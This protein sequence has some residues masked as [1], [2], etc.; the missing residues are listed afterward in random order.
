MTIDEYAKAVAEA[1]RDAA[2]GAAQ[3]RT[4][5]GAIRRIERIDLDAIIASVPRPTAQG[6]KTCLW[7]LFGECVDREPDTT[8]PA[9]HGQTIRPRR[10]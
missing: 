6:V 8:E 2:M 1:V 4:G 9:A 3:I 7:R 10:S 5:F